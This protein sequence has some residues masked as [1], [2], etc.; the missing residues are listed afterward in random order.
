MA[1]AMTYTKTGS[2]SSTKLTLPKEIFEV[3]T[4]DHTLLKQA[5]LA[6]E[7]NARRSNARTLRKGEVRGGGK[8]P[9]KQKGTGR[10]RTGSIR[11]PIWRGG[12]IIFGPTGDENHSKALN[13]KSKRLAIKQAL[14][15]A[16]AAGTISVI[17][18]IEIK[19]G[20]TKEIASLLKKLDISRRCLVLVTDI[21]PEIRRASA[22]LSN[23]SV[24]QATYI[25]TKSI[26]DADHIVIA[27]P[28]LDNLKKWLGA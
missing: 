4:K 12:G 5:Y 17:D 10:A 21:T 28:A 14:T 27:K 8:K 11:N 6:H 2:K 24:K 25:G 18:D 13:V 15:L 22:N 19:D 9:W 3:T 1:Q 23:V 26:L 16:A 20:K 7:A